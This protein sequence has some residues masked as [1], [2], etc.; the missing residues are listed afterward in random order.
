MQSFVKRFK[1]TFGGDPSIYSAQ[2]YDSAGIYI[3]LIGEGASNRLAVHE[4]LKEITDYPG[5]SGKTSIL[6]TGDSEKDMFTLQVIRKKIIEKS[7][8]I[9]TDG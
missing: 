6:S 9:K 2:S 8:P 5:V 3:Q 7:S 4:R 1:T